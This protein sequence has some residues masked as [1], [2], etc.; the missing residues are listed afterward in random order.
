[1]C[2]FHFGMQQDDRLCCAWRMHADMI[3]HQ[4]TTLQQEITDFKLS[5]AFWKHEIYNGIY[6][7]ELS[8]SGHN[9][10]LK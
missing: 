2:F 9:L 6:L 10:N 5:L 7:Y 8:T 4:H 3:K 1:M